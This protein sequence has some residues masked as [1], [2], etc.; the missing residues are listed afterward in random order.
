MLV[1]ISYTQPD[2]DRVLPFVS[3]L[4]SRGY[5]VWMD[6]H[7]LK[8]GQDWRFEIERVMDTAE[9]IL[10]FISA[11]SVDRRGFVQRELR[12]ALDRASEKLLDDIYLIPVL[13]DD[14]IEVPRPLRR[15]HC[16]SASDTRAL[17]RLAD[18]I[19]HQ[20]NRSASQAS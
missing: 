7:D 15:L 3:A 9:I 13:L 18:A 11:N 14:G 16:I 12:S 2:R 1:F 19:D 17:D 4:Q 6:C 10:A 8:P 5:D 20:I